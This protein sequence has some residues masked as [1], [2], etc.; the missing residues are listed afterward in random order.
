MTEDIIYVVNRKGIREPLDFMKILSKLSDIM[1]DK[2]GKQLT[3]INTNNIFSNITSFIID[4]IKTSEIDELCAQIALDKQYIHQEYEVYATRLIINS[5]IKDIYCKLEKTEGSNYVEKIAISLKGV[6]LPN[7]RNLMIKYST[8]FLA[9]L[10]EKNNYKYSYRGFYLL[11]KNKYLLSPLPPAPSYAIETPDFFRL[12]VAIG[13]VVGTGLNDSKCLTELTNE[14]F[15]MIK[16][17]YN[18]MSKRYFT[19]ATPAL[20]NAGT[21]NS[22]YASCV[23]INI[24]DSLKSITGMITDCMMS[25]KHSAGI[26]VHLGHLRG[27]G[28][29]IKGTNGITN[30][31]PNL[32]NVLSKIGDYIDQGGGK[33]PGVISVYVPDWH[34]D[35]MDVLELNNIRQSEMAKTGYKLF[36]AVWMSNL[37]IKKFKQDEEWYLF[38]PDDVDLNIY[39]GFEELYEKSVLE[40]KYKTS[41]KARLLA[42]YIF[43]IQS[44]SGLP[45]I[46]FKDNV[47]LLRNQN[48]I[49]DQS[50]LCT[51]ITLPTNDKEIGV[52]NLAS[53]PVGKYI[54]K[55]KPTGDYIKYEPIIIED[56][57][58]RETMYLDIF[59]L[60]TSVRLIVRMINRMI[61]ITFYATEKGK[62][63][64]LKRRPMAIGIM[65]L[66]DALC[67]LGFIFGSYNACEFRAQ[68]HE[69]IYYYAIDESAKLAAIDGSFDP[70][71]YHE[72]KCAQGLL[73]PIIFKQNFG[74]KYK[75]LFDWEKLGEE[76]KSGHKKLRNSVLTACMPTGTT[77]NILDNST[78]FEPYE[79]NLYRYSAFTKEFIV[80]NKFLI[81]DLKKLGIWNDKFINRF[82]Q[83]SGRIQDIKFN[84]FG[85]VAPKIEEYIKKLYRVCAYE[86][87]PEETIFMCAAA[88]P[89]VDQSQ[90]MNITLPILSINSFNLLILSNKLGLK[91]GNYY[92]KT[93]STTKVEKC[94][95]CV[96]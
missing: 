54:T 36:P 52:C 27:K 11:L 74:I 68:F 61:D 37:F 64:N 77:A 92:V 90:S 66:A 15:D 21:I 34:I 95:N 87:K 71:F 89:Y 41:I 94:D 22:Q 43:K 14:D 42:E 13:I 93:Q 51:E 72:Y 69:I 76:F 19:P 3:H 86:I 82:I 96:I 23:L 70:E 79:S 38:S 30:G 39:E 6:L 91:T 26:G 63:S 65:G 46:L 57:I 85:T 75:Q 7:V 47:N 32:C 58:I 2:Y 49:I 44:V 28:S 18:H 17:Y 10:N 25:Q 56:I 5:F 20:L 73:H 78:C 50:N 81:N 35:L 84:F 48:H 9:I 53:I 33:R 16:N 60:E 83:L 4:G 80:S 45:Y 24:E 62:Y 12:R 8:K 1:S 67:K 40:K 55:Y 59:K 31:I 29:V 88:Q